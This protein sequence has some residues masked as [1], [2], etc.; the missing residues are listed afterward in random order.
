MK[1]ITIDGWA[2]GF[3]LPA[4]GGRLDL[5]YE[6]P[7]THTAWVWV[8]GLLAVVLV[9]LALPGRRREIDDDLPEAQ[10]AAAPAV[11]AE[12]MAGDGRR[13]R[14]LRAAAGAPDIAQGYTAGQAA[15]PADAEAADLTADGPAESSPPVRDP[16]PP[17][18]AEPAA[19]AQDPYAPPGAAGENGYQ[20]GY[21]ERPA[22]PGGY[23]SVPHQRQYGGE[24][25][26]QSYQ[27]GD[28]AEYQGGEYGGG[29]PGGGDP[30]A[31]GYPGGPQAAEYPTG[32]YPQQSYPAD[33]YAADPYAADPYQRQGQYQQGQYPA[34]PYQQGRQQPY[35]D[36]QYV[37]PYGYDQQQ[38]YPDGRYP[39][40]GD[41]TYGGDDPGA[42]RDGSEQQR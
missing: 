25:D 5:S 17:G 35:S 20:E 6:T 4:N 38:P 34:D 1:A 33:P 9:V 19:E 37:D 31:T 18:A 21:P 3:E 41:T 23:P 29:Y 11:T 15:D 26:G 14:R 28:Y 22:A 16:A 27:G 36:G 39:A 12:E 2:Q 40:Q 13:A 32:G 7:L 24:W 30:Q 10:G 42:D 8:Q